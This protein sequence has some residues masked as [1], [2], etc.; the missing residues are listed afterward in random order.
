MECVHRKPWSVPL[1][2]FALWLPT[3]GNNR[4][5]EKRREEWREGIKEVKEEEGG[6]RKESYRKEAGK[7]GKDGKGER[8][9][10]REEKKQKWG[11]A[12]EE[13]KGKETEEGGG[14]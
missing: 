10:M 3:L 12:A 1:P 6:K 2:C 8:Q 7:E 9:E 5:R 4:A 11:V 14:E 13:L